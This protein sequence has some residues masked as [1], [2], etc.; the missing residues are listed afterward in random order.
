MIRKRR[1]PSSPSIL[2]KFAAARRCAPMRD[3]RDGGMAALAAVIFLFAVH[4]L[5][6]RLLMFVM[7]VMFS[8]ASIYIRLGLAGLY[9][10]L[11]REME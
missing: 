11:K 1:T 8:L 6:G 3:A 10:E 4:V 7:I 9:T 5:S 2:K